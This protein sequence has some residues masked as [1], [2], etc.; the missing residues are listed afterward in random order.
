[1]R[2]TFLFGSLVAATVFGL[3]MFAYADEP[4]DEAKIEAGAAT[5][6][7]YC[8]TCHGDNL[9]NT[10]QSF[11]L[12]RLKADER[13]R[14]ENSVTNGKNQMPPWKG[15]LDAEQIDDLWHYIRANAYTK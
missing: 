9:V 4:T 5:F 6:S 15:V 2:R 13:P 11:D 8:S 7:D 3:P 1:V 14:F 12:R 10:G